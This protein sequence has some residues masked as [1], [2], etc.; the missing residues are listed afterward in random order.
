MGKRPIGRKSSDLRK[1]HS[2][3]ASEKRWKCTT[4]AALARHLGYSPR[5]V[6]EYCKSRLIPEAYRTQGGHWRIR[7][8]LSVKTRFRLLKL[9]GD[10]PS[11]GRD[12]E[13]EF[14]ADSAEN[15][16]PSQLCQMDE[17]DF[18]AKPFLPGIKEPS[19]QECVFV[20]HASNCTAEPNKKDS[21]IMRKR[22]MA[23]RIRSKIY[24]KVASGAS[25]NPL[26]LIGEVYQFWRKNLRSPKVTE[27][28][29]Q[30]RI[31]RG[32]FYRR[33]TPEGLNMAYLVASG[34][35]GRRVLPDLD[36][37]NPVQRANI[38]ARR[39]TYTSDNYDPFD[40]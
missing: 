24:K 36:G 22:E 8:P 38:R 10:W 15:L 35:V 1:A 25:L 34:E 11:G 20:A 18:I 40:D 2:E 9:L 19:E 3:R 33:F 21:E 28:A 16:L 12:A 17:D 39:R 7:L 23:S 26:I 30:M 5:T 37:L 27:I 13:G 6:R 4:P 31:S 32:T 14:E 29:K